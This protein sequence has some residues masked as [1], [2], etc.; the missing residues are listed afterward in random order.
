MKKI[1][2]LVPI[3]IVGQLAIAQPRGEKVASIKIGFL[4]EKLHLDP[5][6]AEQFWPIYNQYDDEIRGLIQDK[7]NKDDQRSAQEILDQEQ[8][9]I[10]IKRK[11]SAQFLR[12]IN[13][14][15]LAQLYQSEREFN[16][17]LIRRMNK[18]EN[19]Q[20]KKNNREEPGMQGR[21]MRP[22]MGGRG[23]GR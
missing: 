17:M 8:K 22:R 5:K 3:L 20:E 11:Y 13:N 10:D 15:Q 23:F 6:T 21:Q 9:A 14:E 18:M 12:V 19:R 1:F 16:M 7:R 2:L 4:T